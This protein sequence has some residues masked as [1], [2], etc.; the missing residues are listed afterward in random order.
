[1]KFLKDRTLYN[2]QEYKTYKNKL[3]SILRYCEKNYFSD[4]LNRNSM[5]TK[6][7]WKIL[8]NITNTKNKNKTSISLFYN[9]KL[10]DNKQAVANAFNDY[11]INIAHEL[12]QNIS[13]TNV[14]S[15]KIFLKNRNNNSMFIFP[16]TE[17]EL[18]DVVNKFKSKKSSDF[19]EFSMEMIK[20]SLI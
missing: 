12:M 11:F 5:N 10:I 20:K 15:F 16:I 18:M 8:N 4:L 6:E 2:E 3:T 7:T 1:M 17:E 14:S 9:G 13:N 19:N